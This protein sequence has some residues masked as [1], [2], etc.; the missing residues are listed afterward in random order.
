M[1][2]DVEVNSWTEL[3]TAIDFAAASGRWGATVISLTSDID[4]NTEAPEGVKHTISTYA[5]DNSGTLV[6][7]GQG[8]KIQN[9]RTN[10]SSPGD[11]LYLSSSLNTMVVSGLHWKNTDFVNI[12]L[13]GGSFFNYNTSKFNLTFQMTNC[14]FVGSRGGIAYLVGTTPTGAW[15]SLT[16]TSCFFDI[17]W[18]GAG[19][20]S[21]AL[22]PTSLIPKVYNSTP[23]VSANYCWFREKY[24]GWAY[25]SYSYSNPSRF[26]SFSFM[27]INGCY[28]DGSMIIP[29]NDSSAFAGLL[30]P[31]SADI[32]VA[33][34]PSTQNVFDCQI[35]T[36]ANTAQIYYY[37]FY[38]LLRTGAQKP[39]GSVFADEAYS[40]MGHEAKPYPILATPARMKDATWLSNAGFDIIIP[41]E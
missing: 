12:I 23:R 41:S 15:D 31:L 21:D 16:F 35:T 25:G 17:P 10:I 24:T 27:K 2:Y 40:R 14:R 13:S 37:N 19:V 30:Y 7:D 6:I 38:G 33:Y 11:I 8:H 18:Q 20:S 1:P 4:M 22:D 29:N 36:Q 3:M 34:T 5:N 32:V 9:L 39:D 26:F 28:I